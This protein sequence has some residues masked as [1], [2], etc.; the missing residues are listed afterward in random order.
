VFAWK[1]L[2]APAL[3][4]AVVVVAANVLV[5]YPINKWFTWAAI[6]YPLTYFVTDISNRWAGARL[7]RGVAWAGFVTG[8]TFSL[9]FQ[10]PWRIALASGAAFI[11]SQLLDIAV[12]NKLRKRSWW[13]APFW[14]SSAASVIDTLI[15][16]SIAFAGTE[17]SWLHL[18]AGDIAVKLA[19]AVVLLAPFRVFIAWMGLMPVKKP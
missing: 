2:I 4:M 10:V 6:V 5:Q 7:A 13:K 11:V 9:V 18:A 15:F 1:Q 16:F 12:F 14:G 8:V 19:M 17:R 3:C